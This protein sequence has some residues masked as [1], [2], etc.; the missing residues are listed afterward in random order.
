ME[1]YFIT[2]GS[3]ESN[4]QNSKNE[5]T[6][7]D[8]AVVNAGIGNINVVTVSSMIPPGTKEIPFKPQNWGDIVFCIMA[9]NDGRKGSFISCGLLVVEVFMEN[10]LQGSMVLE[11]SGRGTSNTA[12]KNLYDEL[13]DMVKRRKVYTFVPKRFVYNSLKVKKRYGT[14]LCSICFS[15]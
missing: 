12:L 6:S 4:L 14:V 9:R 8:D 15:R 7:Y 2:K 1:H 5:T 11:Y 13:G 3:G 10:K